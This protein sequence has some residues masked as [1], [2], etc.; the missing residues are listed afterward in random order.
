MKVENVKVYNIARAVYSA[1]NAL[2]SW[3]KSDSDLDNDI[4]GKCDIELARRLYKGGCEHRKYLRQI[5]VTMDIEAP[6]YW[7]Q[8]LDTYKVGT[9]RNSCSLQHKGAS[10]D[11]TLDDFSYD[12]EI[13]QEDMQMVIDL[14]NKYRQLYEDTKNYAFFI[15]MRQLMPMGYNYRFTLSM[16]YENVV[17]MIHQR[18][19]HRLPEWKE[20]TGILYELP[21]IKEIIGD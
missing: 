11:F 9:T 19:N 4:L 14:V 1:R 17:N 7:I 13:M 5:F 12:P 21:Y 18:S 8:E 16:N 20:F 3:N 15:A 10:R 2:N 6:V